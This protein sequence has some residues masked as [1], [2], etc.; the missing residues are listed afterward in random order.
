MLRSLKWVNENY[1][2]PAKRGMRVQVNGKFG[3]IT[4]S[5]GQYIMVRMDGEKHPDV[6]HPT[7]EFVYYDKDNNILKDT[8]KVAISELR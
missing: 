3:H 5:S 4:S 6:C 2:V 1:H 7:Y 8:R